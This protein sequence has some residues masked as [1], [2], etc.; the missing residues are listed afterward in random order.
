MNNNQQWIFKNYFWIKVNLPMSVC[1]KNHIN[2]SNTTNPKNIKGRKIINKSE[3]IHVDLKN[4][5]HKPLKV[6][7]DDHKVNK[8]LLKNDKYLKNKCPHKHNTLMADD[9]L[10]R[11]FFPKINLSDSSEIDVI[12]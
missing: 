8:F 10:Y 3:K 5:K 12:S 4:R 1:P 11:I 6:K 9:E 7:T 2:P